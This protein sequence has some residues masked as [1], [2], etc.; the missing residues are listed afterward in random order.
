MGVATVPA[1]AAWP[2][3]SSGD[4]SSDLAKYNQL[5]V[6]GIWGGTCGGG[7]VSVVRGELWRPPSHLHTLPLQARKKQFKFSKSTIHNWGL[8]AMEAIAA[9]EMAIE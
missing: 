6:G 4:I 5:R 2:V 7:L 9:D 3:F 1:S 8:F